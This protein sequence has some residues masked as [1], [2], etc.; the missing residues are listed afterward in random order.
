MYFQYL[1]LCICKELATTKERTNT[2]AFMTPNIRSA[3]M[4]FVLAKS[5]Q[6]NLS[7]IN[8]VSL[9]VDD[10]ENVVIFCRLAYLNWKRVIKSK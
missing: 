10:L 8:P 7:I 6:V 2:Y 1:I 9:R 5:G 4:G 3:R